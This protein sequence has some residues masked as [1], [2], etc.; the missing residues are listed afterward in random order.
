MLKATILPIK[1]R[2]LRVRNRNDH[3]I[4]I[5]QTIHDLVRP[6]DQHMG[7]MPTVNTTAKFRKSSK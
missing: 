2:Q 3:N 1:R 7:A 5:N 6:T 4:V